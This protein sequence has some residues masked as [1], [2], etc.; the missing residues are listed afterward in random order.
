MENGE[1]MKRA[2]VWLAFVLVLFAPY[3][4]TLSQDA[5]SSSSIEEDIREL[6]ELTG[7]E[8]LAIQI[9]NQMLVPMMEAMPDVP[10]SA[11]CKR[12]HTT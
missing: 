11:C 12:R 9:M 2:T 10:Q 6:M 5:V 7:M 4:C 1:N 8:S 3:G